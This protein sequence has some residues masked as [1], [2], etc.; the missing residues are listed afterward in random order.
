MVPGLRLLH[1]AHARVPQAGF[2]SDG[3]DIIEH[4]QHS[5]DKRTIIQWSPA[6]IDKEKYRMVY[7]QAFCLLHDGHQSPANLALPSAQ[8]QL[9]GGTGS[10]DSY[11]G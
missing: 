6:I 1:D 11:S 7:L 5:F 2:Y 10:A 3:E 9:Y 8:C 4:H